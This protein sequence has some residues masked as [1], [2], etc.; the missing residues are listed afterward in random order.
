MKQTIIAL[1]L[2]TF[3][4]A[5]FAQKAVN[6][7]LVKAGI[8]EYPKLL[9]RFNTFDPTLTIDDY[10]L[11]YYGTVFQPGYSADPELKQKEISAAIG[12]RD[13]TN[14]IALCDSVLKKYPVSMTANFAK[15]L[16]LISANPNDTVYHAYMN[17][18]A[19]IIR[20]ILSSGNGKTAK[21]A[22]KTIFVADDYELIYKYFGITKVIAQNM[23][24][25]NDVFEVQPSDK[26]VDKKIYFDAE[27][28]IKQYKK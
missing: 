16:A 20:T 17:R 15:G 22:F 7:E 23:E 18:Y 19:T 26:W 21:T 2:F 12:K 6:M 4:C 10:R 28:I 8:A 11:L 24:G 3:S 9:A 13:F 5:A 1:L 27:E 25:K 14:V